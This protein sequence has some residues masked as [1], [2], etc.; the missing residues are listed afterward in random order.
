MFSLKMSFEELFCISHIS[1]A[2]ICCFNGPFLWVA[3][4]LKAVLLEREPFLN[5]SGVNDI[6]LFRA[7]CLIGLLVLRMWF[8]GYVISLAIFVLWIR[9]EIG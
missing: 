6:G 3:H 4:P 1:V 5:P 9:D 8:A 7:K 2:I